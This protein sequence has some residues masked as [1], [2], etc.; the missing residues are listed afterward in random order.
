MKANKINLEEMAAKVLAEAQ[1]K[2]LTT[3]YFFETTFK[4]Y[5]MQL[6][7]LDKLENAINENGALI[8]K[9]YVKGR[10]NLCANPAITEYNKTATAANGT[11]STLINILKTLPA[12]SESVG[13][14]QDKLQS[15]ID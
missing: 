2:G 12:Q 14:L 15:L 5:K 3:N 11:A 9:E 8:T 13:S 1:N 6:E 4:R 7:I 10:E